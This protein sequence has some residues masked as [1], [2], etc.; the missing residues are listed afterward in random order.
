M[1]KLEWLGY[2]MA[3]NISKIS[4]FVLTECTNVTDR[5]T[6]TDTGWWHRPRLHSI[7]RQKRLKCRYETVRT[8]WQWHFD[9]AVKF[10]RVV[11][12]SSGGAGWGLMCIA[13]LILMYFVPAM[14]QF[15]TTYDMPINLD[16]TAT[17]IRLYVCRKVKLLTSLVNCFLA[18]RWW[19]VKWSKRV[20]V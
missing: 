3:K 9:H 15:L 4:L 20:F 7:A 2:P 1:E 11:V 19:W 8:D 13:L 12:P 5:Q 17:W 14:C 6:Q 18:V 10:A 16:Y